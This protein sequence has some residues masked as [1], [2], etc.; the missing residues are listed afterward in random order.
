MDSKYL[1]SAAKPEQLASFG[2]PEVSFIGRSNCGKSTLLNALL[3]R[4]N[5]ARTS[6]TPGRTQMVNFFSLNDEMIFADLPG[7]GFSVASKHTEKTWNDLMAAY[8]ERPDISTFLFL[9]DIRRKP[10]PFELEFLLHLSQTAPLIIVLTKIDKVKTN[11]RKKLSKN[12]VM[13]LETSGIEHEAII[14]VSSLK[15]EGIA[16]LFE[17]IKMLAEH[18]KEAGIQTSNN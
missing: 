11:E 17:K 8:C 13:S 14:E 15:K 12:F 16:K 10:Q 1:T 18:S 6:S 4:K 2:L 3:G 7:Y 5:L 9:C